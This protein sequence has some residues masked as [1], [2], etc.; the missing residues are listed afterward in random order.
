MQEMAAGA[1]GLFGV[2]GRGQSIL[3]PAVPAPLRCPCPHFP[4]SPVSGG[5]FPCVQQGTAVAVS[6]SYVTHV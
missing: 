3:V 5:P 6:K 4:I 1:A 2:W